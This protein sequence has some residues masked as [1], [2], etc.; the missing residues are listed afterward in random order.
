MRGGLGI[1][2]C[3]FDLDFF[4]LTLPQSH[5]H[6]HHTRILNQGHNEV[7]KLLYFDRRCLR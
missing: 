1:G 3:D 4:S 2:I 6:G 5:Y 7:S